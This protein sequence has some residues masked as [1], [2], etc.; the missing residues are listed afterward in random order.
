MERCRRVLPVVAKPMRY[1]QMSG[2]SLASEMELPFALPTQQQG[3][4]DV[5]IRQRPVPERLEGAIHANPFWEMTARRMLLRL[6]GI[7]R[8]L[9]NE[10]RQLDMDPE[11]GT[12][13]AD[14]LPFLLST[15]FGALLY[16]RGGLALHGAAV[17]DEGRAY[18]FCGISGIGKSTLAA[19]LCRIGC[20]F[21]AD[22]IA[23]IDLAE[24]DRPFISP[25]GRYLQ[26]FENSVQTLSI[27]TACRGRVRNQIDKF[28][29]NP[30]KIA[31]H[32]PPLAA[33]YLLRDSSPRDQLGIQAM[34]RIDSAQT[35]LNQ[36]YRPDIALTLARTGRQ[37]EITAAILRHAPLFK[38][39]LARDLS[40]VETL[41]AQLRD[42]W[43]GCKK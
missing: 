20:E 25:D 30:D 24:H 36:N 37:I 29:V 14:A 7:G 27:E 3:Q 39:T 11:P 17:A 15:C 12:D 28:F 8:F 23:A 13:P 32:M 18:L 22:N 31:N 26:L 2:L 4:A 43:R 40:Q 21:V 5:L 41:A 6:P 9:A 35:I 34:S 10:G 16:Q 19:A 42:H 1:Y 38:V 33:I